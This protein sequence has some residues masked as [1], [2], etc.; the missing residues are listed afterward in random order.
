MAENV[1]GALFQYVEHRDGRNTVSYMSPRCLDL[2]EVPP[3]AIEADASVLW[4]MVHPDD[5]PGM[6]ASVAES[7]RTMERWYWEWR[8]TTPSG[9]LKWLQGT[10]R[11]RRI[12]DET[13]AWDSFILD[14][15]DRRRADEEQ[16]RLRAQLRH[17]QQLEAIGRLAGGI[18][19]DVNNMLTVVMGYAESAL[20]SLPEGAPAR[21]DLAEILSVASRSAG[22]TRQ[23]LAFARQQPS[24]PQVIDVAE[25]LEDSA[26]LLHRLVG[27]SVA[28]EF[29]LDAGVP[30]VDIDPSQLD[31]IV[32]N[33]VV[34]ARDAM[35][36]GGTITIAL[37]R[38]GDRVVLEVSDTGNGMD[39]ATR[40]RIFEPFFTTKPD[41]Q[42]TGLG[43]ATVFGIV[44]ERGGLV[45]LETEREVGTTFRIVL[46]RA[47][48]SAPVET[49]DPQPAQRDL[50]EE[51]L[52][53][54]DDPPLRRILQR[55]LERR[56]LRVQVAASPEDA[57]TLAAAHPPQLLVT[58]VVTG[59]RGGVGL[60]ADL[61]RAQ[62]TLP[63]VYI[64]GYVTDELARRALESG[65]EQ[66]LR[67]PFRGADLIAAVARA[68]EARRP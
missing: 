46:P 60:S 44:S 33:L 52:L 66:V 37:H 2:W 22:L 32:T 34:N 29:E 50:P 59:G 5:L 4:Q 39:A 30:P 27:A 6:A 20:L 25:R 36:H 7:A 26:T 43:L 56:G 38:D 35:P 47:T 24:T 53:C 16:Q 15:T 17:A 68:W 41:G 45:T 19:H 65:T 18:A 51:V 48:R 63:V 67:K 11:P 14:V 55:M 42:G 49:N 62:P 21:E 13:V 31:Q 54:E 64:T 40:A 12:N 23:L 9:K 28:L 1:P 8:I 3:E 61:R 57:L 58:D 10:G